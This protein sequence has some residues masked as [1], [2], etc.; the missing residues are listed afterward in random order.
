MFVLNNHCVSLFRDLSSMDHNIFFLYKLL[1]S[2]VFCG[3]FRFS[4]QHPNCLLF[5]GLSFV[6]VSSKFVSHICGG[7]T[8]RALLENMECRAFVLFTHNSSFQSLSVPRVVESFSLYYRCFN[9]YCF[10]ELSSLI[11]SPLLRWERLVKNVFSHSFNLSM[12]N[13]LTQDLAVIS[14]HTCRLLVIF[15][16]RKIKYNFWYFFLPFKFFKLGKK[17]KIYLCFFFIPLCLF[18]KHHYLIFC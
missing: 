10:T 18:S 5:M 2:W 1:R 8:V 15:S 16:S 11:H 14:S 3:S 9:G 17:F 12:Y 13:S 4:S 6:L 7:S